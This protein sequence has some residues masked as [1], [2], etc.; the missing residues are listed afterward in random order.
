MGYSSDVVNN[1]LYQRIS[2]LTDEQVLK[3]AEVKMAK[4]SRIAREMS[5]LAEACNEGLLD[6]A[7]LARYDKL[8]EAVCYRGTLAKAIAIRVAK[9]R[10]ILDFSKFPSLRGE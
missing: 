5:A 10:G 1:K 9:E 8:I 4:S 2:G 7:G 6:E 3:L